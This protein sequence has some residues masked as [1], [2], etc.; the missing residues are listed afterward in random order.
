MLG[1]RACVGAPD[2]HAGGKRNRRTL[3][4]LKIIPAVAAWCARYNATGKR[5]HD[6]LASLFD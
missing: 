1:F 5:R 3:D 4:F 2:G 6:A